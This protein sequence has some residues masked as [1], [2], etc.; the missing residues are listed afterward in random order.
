[1]RQPLCKDGIM[2]IGAVPGVPDLAA[3]PGASWG[4]GWRWAAGRSAIIS[5][6]VNPTRSV[7]C[8]CVFSS[9]VSSAGPLDPRSRVVVNTKRV[10][11]ANRTTWWILNRICWNT[12]F[13]LRNMICG[14]LSASYF[15]FSCSP[16][17]PL[18]SLTWFEGVDLSYFLSSICS[19][20][21]CCWDFKT[22]SAREKFS[23]GVTEEI[24]IDKRNQNWLE[25]NWFEG[26]TMIGCYQ[27]LGFKA[28]HKGSLNLLHNPVRYGVL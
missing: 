28:E 12:R 15:F 10:R 24:D 23:W 8:V 19:L 17:R 7:Y 13:L 9:S 14:L 25:F 2:M 5:N 22:P 16:T 6:H 1:M 26:I 21:L 11:V 3:A 27:L 4:P 18:F 20:E